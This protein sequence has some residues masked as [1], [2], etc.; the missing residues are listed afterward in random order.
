M[1]S[2]S[3]VKNL[4][5]KQHKNFFFLISL[6]LLLLTTSCS[7]LSTS[8]GIVAVSIFSDGKTIQ[9]DVPA[10]STVQNAIDQAGISINNLDAVTPPLFSN[11]TLPVE[12]KIT[13]VR[14]EFEIVD[15]I[16]P[17]EKQSVRNESMPEGQTLM[18]QTGVNGLQQITYRQLYEDDAPTT[19]TTFKIETIEVPRPEIIMVGVQ[20]PFV[21]LEIEHR[22]AYLTAGNAW[23]MEKK[24]GTR[25]PIVTTG[26][27]DGRIFSLSPDAKWLLFTRKIDSSIDSVTINSLW[28]AKLDKDPV[29]IIDLDT[30]NIIHFAEWVPGGANLLSYSTVEP[31]TTAPG[32]QA[33]N[34]LWNLSFT[35]SGKITKDNIIESNSGGIYGWWGANFSWSPNGTYLAYARPDSVGIVSF[36]DQEFKPLLTLNPYLTQGD[37]AWVPDISWS[38]DEKTIYSVNHSQATNSSTQTAS[39][40]FDVIAINMENES[41]TSISANTGMF[42]SPT[43]SNTQNNKRYQIAYLQAIFSEQSD[44]SR[45]KLMTVDKDGSNRKMIFPPDGSAGIEPQ[46]IVWS[47]YSSE[48]ENFIAFIYQGNLWLYNTI[49]LQ[50]QQ[51]TGDGLISR[52]DW[53]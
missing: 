26:D 13:R 29:L 1:P 23:I 32:W 33:N 17:F 3:E 46:N 27:L 50:A 49:N 47:P 19:R 41:V 28:V 37:W 51:I 16:I 14:E 34:D 48:S 21:S 31:R 6:L 36:K 20:S 18:I 38:E 44:T 22:I 11:I 10:G 8:Q 2:Y 45:Y 4:F 12:I 40:T 35:E 39:N 42:S 9:I 24:T 25:K 15:N 7:P 5:F 30:T 52:I 43:P 53:K